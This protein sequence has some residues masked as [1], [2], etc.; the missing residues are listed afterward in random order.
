M[1]AIVSWMWNS[2]YKEA[3]QNRFST[4]SKLIATPVERESGDDDNEWVVVRAKEIAWSEREIPSG[5]YGSSSSENG[6]EWLAACSQG[7]LCSVSQQAVGGQVDLNQGLLRACENGKGDVSNMLLAF[8]ATDVE[9]AL[10]GACRNGHTNEAKLMLRAGANNIY[11][12]L[13]DACQN[14]H[15]DTITFLIGKRTLNYMYLNEALC[16]ALSNDQIETALYLLDHGATT[17]NSILT[18]AC[19]KKDRELG[20]RILKLGADLCSNCDLPIAT[21]T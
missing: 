1:Q 18:Y 16:H 21:H 6:E 5:A 10:R 8:G 20:R 12:A 14:G 9:A 17:V 3:N 13:C 11:S 4:F 15:V 19:K 2:K 7:D